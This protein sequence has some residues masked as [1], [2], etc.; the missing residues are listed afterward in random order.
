MYYGSNGSAS[1]NSD[2]ASLLT[3]DSVIMSMDL[4]ILYGEYAIGQVL[5]EAALTVPFDGRLEIVAP[6]DVQA[7]A[8]ADGAAS[9]IITAVTYADSSHVYL[10]SYGWQGDT[11]TVYEAKTVETTSDGVS[12]AAT[13]LASQGYA[14]SAFG[15]NNTLGLVIVG[16]RVQGDTMPRPLI[17]STLNKEGATISSVPTNPG[18]VSYTEV[19]DLTP[20]GGGYIGVEEQ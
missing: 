10:L 13:Q 1:F 18:P 5:S 20:K 17:I 19:I 8:T 2:L 6:A 14:I 7:T 12:A 16:I 11:S 15:G 9:R 4:S 3:P